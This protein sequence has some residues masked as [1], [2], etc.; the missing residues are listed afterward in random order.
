[1]DGEQSRKESGDRGSWP[2]AVYR[3]GHEPGDD[4]SASTTPEAR[5]AM[6]WT[7]TLEAWSL[8]GRDLPEYPRSETPVSRRPGPPPPGAA[9]SR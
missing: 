4:L 9:S 6:V 2:V 5:L 1:V 8:S 3:L 7:L